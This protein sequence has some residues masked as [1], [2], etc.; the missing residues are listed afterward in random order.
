MASNDNDSEVMERQRRGR[1][2]TA[3]APSDGKPSMM[4]MLWADLRKRPV[5]S[6][7]SDDELAYLEEEERMRQEANEVLAK[8][9]TLDDS[10]V[11]QM[12]RRYG[13]S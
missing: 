12:R 3:P 5:A 10:R 8:A 4:H 11:E 7:P 6:E 2:R 9:H 13:V 1:R